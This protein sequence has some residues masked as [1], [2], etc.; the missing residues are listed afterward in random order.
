VRVFPARTWRR[1][2]VRCAAAEAFAA[3]SALSPDCLRALTKVSPCEIFVSTGNLACSRT[4]AASA[5]AIC[6]WCW[7]SATAAVLDRETCQ[8]MAQPAANTTN[9][10][11]TKRRYKF[12]PGHSLSVPAAASSAA[13]VSRWP[14][15]SPIA[16]KRNRLRR[17]SNLHTFVS[18]ARFRQ[19]RFGGCAPNH[20]Q[21][22]SYSSETLRAAL[23]FSGSHSLSILL[24][25]G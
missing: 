17:Q 21:S 23:T 20:Q 19:I 24:S 3:S 7:M 25:I 9:K 8:T 10:A 14:D 16:V 1:L 22:V 13:S 15:G 5:R 2:N 11:I 18:N 6:A 4:C 12:P